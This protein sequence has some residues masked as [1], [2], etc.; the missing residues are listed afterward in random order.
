[1]D[2]KREIIEM[3]KKMKNEGYLRKIYFFVKTI[4]EKDRDH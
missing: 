3:V 4:F 1:M 2:Y